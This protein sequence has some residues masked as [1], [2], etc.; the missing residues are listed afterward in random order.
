MLRFVNRRGRVNIG[1]DIGFKGIRGLLHVR[2]DDIPLMTSSRK[3][4]DKSPMWDNN[5][6]IASRRM[7]RCSTAVNASFLSN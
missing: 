3:G 6:K 5:G 2:F 4:T 1:V 7:I